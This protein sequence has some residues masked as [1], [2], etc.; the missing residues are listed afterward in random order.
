M[1]PCRV[2][3]G[4]TTFGCRDDAE[5]PAG[6]GPCTGGGG[7]GVQPNQC[8]DL[9]C[10]PEGECPNGPIDTFCDGALHPNGEG[11]LT[12]SND[13]DCSLDGQGACTISQP[14]RCYP[15]PIT[16]SGSPGV[17]GA[18]VGGLACIGLTTSA[19]IN[20]ASGLPG[21]FKIELDFDSEPACASDPSLPWYPPAGANCTATA[22]T[23]TTTLFPPLP[24]VAGIPPACGGTC[25]PGEVCAS[26]GLT[27]ACQAGGTTTTTM[28]PAGGCGTAEFPLCGLGACP[29]GSTCQLD[30]MN[31]TCTCTP[32]TACA[33]TF[34]PICGGT[35]PLGQ[36]CQGNIQGLAC[37]CG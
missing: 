3:A 14:R 34:F 22:S 2:C 11:Y 10:S 37:A 8:A 36:A 27:C 15:N 30:L 1:C 13:L 20:I 32:G 21:A 9:N 6:I 24:C 19:V 25:P 12:C 31:S 28:P 18:D 4:D 16:V 5:C 23:T 33:D 7:A 35:C 26:N 17:F 29:A